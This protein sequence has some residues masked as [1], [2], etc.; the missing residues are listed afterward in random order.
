[1][2]KKALIKSEDWIVISDDIGPD[3]IVE[4]M[5]SKKL[6]ADI[7]IFSQ[8][9]PHINP[10]YDYYYEYKNLA[11]IPI[12]TYDNWWTY[13][14]QV[15]RKNV[16]RSEKRGIKIK[17]INFDDELVRAIIRINNSAPV[18]QARKFTHYGKDFN[19][20]KKDYSE[21]SDR[22]LYLGAFY[23]DEMVG[24]LR[25]VFLGKV[26]SV[27]QLL[28]MPQYYDKRPANALIAK[29]VEICAEKGIEYLIYG[30]F[31]YNHNKWS[32]MVEFKRRN[33]FVQM[34]LPVYYIPLTIK[35]RLLIKLRLHKGIRGAVP[36]IIFKLFYWLRRYIYNIKYRKFK[37]RN[38]TNLD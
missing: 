11:V 28:C 1:M 24:F 12:T 30:Q 36:P 3:I 25:L 16:R 37:N 33:G 19:K 15:T 4:K 23:Q 7:L 8:K 5:R 17:T 18:R 35:G 31:I 27:M 22:S 29:T 20:V 26:A 6:K 38:E 14:P 21:F 2:V 13:L 34:L 10:R 9:P 32:S